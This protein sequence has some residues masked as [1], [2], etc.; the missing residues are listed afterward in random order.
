MTD[1]ME[2]KRMF[3]LPFHNNASTRS[4]PTLLGGIGRRHLQ[5]FHRAQTNLPFAQRAADTG[6]TPLSFCS[7]HQTTT[8]QTHGESQ[9]L[10]LWAEPSPCV[11]HGLQGDGGRAGSI[12]HQQGLAQ[13][14]GKVQWCCVASM[15]AGRV[16]TA[17]EQQVLLQM[18][19]R[20]C[21]EK[22]KK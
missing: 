3:R 16:T 12:Q 4:H 6:S 11:S 19:P 15:G 21:Q 8:S 10:L 17:S 20:Y 9:I 18:P 14:W 2:V 1:S 13:R 5:D 7:C 22:K